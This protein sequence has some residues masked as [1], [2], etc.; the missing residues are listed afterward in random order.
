MLFH[1]SPPVGIAFIAKGFSK[2]VA[3]PA[4]IPLVTPHNPTR[5]FCDCSCLVSLDKE[6]QTSDGRSELLLRA[7]L[8]GARTGRSLQTRKAR[9]SESFDFGGHRIRAMGAGATM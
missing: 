8:P 6:F 3:V 7:D 9:K 2:R 1:L 4:T 5:I